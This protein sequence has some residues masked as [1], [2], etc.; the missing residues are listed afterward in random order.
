M[1]STS[2][3]PRSSAEQQRQSSTTPETKLAQDVREEAPLDLAARTRIAVYRRASQRAPPN[4][5]DASV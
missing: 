4:Q 5:S 2:P 1:A 3:P